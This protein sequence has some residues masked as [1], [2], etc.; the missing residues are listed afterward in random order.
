MVRNVQFLNGSP[1]YM[2][3]EFEN[4]TNKVSEKSNFRISGL[5]YSDG[6]RNCLKDSELMSSINFKL[7]SKKK[8]YFTFSA[9]QRGPHLAG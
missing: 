6:H 9:R 7:F 5:L 2:I 1:N 4:W 3:R 8:F